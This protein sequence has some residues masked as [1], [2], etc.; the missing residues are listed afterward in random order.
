MMWH[1]AAKC[2]QKRMNSLHV[3]MYG[4]SPEMLF[5]DTKAVNVQLK[6]YHT[7]VCPVYILDLRLQ[8][9]PKGVTK[10]EP[11]SRFGI[12]FGHSPAHA[13][14]VALVF[15]PETG[16][17]S[18]QYHVVFDYQF[19]TVPHMRNL[20]VP[21]NW[22]QVVKHSRELFKTEQFDLNK[23]WFE[24][25]NDITAGTILQLPNE[26]GSMVN[27]QDNI[28]QSQADTVP[29]EVGVC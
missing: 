23:T 17:A 26:N 3:N 14:S 15:N 13:G 25:E 21:S 28:D 7:F 12:Y 6:H 10:W 16:L 20:T 8:T 18:P 11:R 5:L 29:H 4:E 9:N 1:F 2:A 27:L 24:G 19:K 22:E